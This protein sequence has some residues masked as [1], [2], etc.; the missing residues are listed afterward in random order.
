MLTHL[1]GPATLQP[2]PHPSQRVRARTRA[3]PFSARRGVTHEKAPR[4][5]KD[6]KGALPR[7]RGCGVTDEVE[8]EVAEQPVDLGA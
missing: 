2:N 1:P 4:H 6:S 5:V 8:R 7:G 3:S